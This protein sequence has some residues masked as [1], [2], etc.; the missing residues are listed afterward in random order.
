MTNGT[1]EAVATTLQ[2]KEEE[3][4]TQALRQNGFHF[5]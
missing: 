1:Q 5:L 4:V 3:H 2:T